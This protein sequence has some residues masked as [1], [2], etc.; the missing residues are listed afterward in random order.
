MCPNRT[1]SKVLAAIFGEPVR[2]T[3]SSTFASITGDHRRSMAGRRTA[4]V[5][6]FLSPTTF[7]L[8][9]DHLIATMRRAE[10]AGSH[11]NRLA[12]ILEIRH[13]LLLHEKEPV[14]P[15][16]TPG[17]RPV[18]RW[19]W[20]V[21][22]RRSLPVPGPVFSR[23]P[24]TRPLIRLAFRPQSAQ[25]YVQCSGAAPHRGDHGC[26]RRLRCRFAA[27]AITTPLSSALPSPSVPPQPPW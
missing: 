19:K 24:S 17:R 5:S 21:W 11:R 8:L 4:R 2:D 23:L 7:R 14:E 26:R 20:V 1:V 6:F 9:L 15:A 10:L 13:R 16:A 18:C 3:I 25:S 22:A 27:F 12:K